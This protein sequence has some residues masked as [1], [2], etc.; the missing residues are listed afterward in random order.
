MKIINTKVEEML[1]ALDEESEEILSGYSIMGTLENGREILLA[2]I[3]A[4]TH[5][6]IGAELHEDLGTPSLDETL[7]IAQLL[8]AAPQMRKIIEDLSAEALQN[9]GYISRETMTAALK[10]ISSISED[11]NC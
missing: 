3:T 6:A 11:E 2:D 9:E 4:T 7:H 5:P 1:V 8:A 10:I